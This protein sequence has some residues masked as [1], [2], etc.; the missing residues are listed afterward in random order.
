MSH[1]LNL[2]TTLTDKE[3]IIRGLVRK[4][5]PRNKIEVHDRAQTM[6]MYA[7]QTGSANIIVRQENIQ[8]LKSEIG[9]STQY[10]HAFA[11]LGFRQNPDG[12]YEAVVDG[13]NFDEGWVNNLSQC[14]NVEKAKMELDAKKIK[15]T[16]TV[17]P[18]GD[19]QLRAAFQQQQAR[20]R[21]VQSRTVSFG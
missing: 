12:T 21:R 4:G 6:A 15:Y 20:N 17:T 2:K 16:E 13:S 7:G 11:D 18:T 5:I 1:T 14:Y 9:M 3:A 10:A 8:A 19:I